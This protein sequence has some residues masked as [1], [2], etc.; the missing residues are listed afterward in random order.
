M[1]FLA[2]ISY[3]FVWKLYSLIIKVILVIFYNFKIGKNF[4][5]KGTPILKLKGNNNIE[6]GNNV[7]ILGDIDLRTREN[8]KLIILD[9]V[10]IEENCRFVVAKEG[11]TKIGNNTVIGAY[12]IWNGGG[13]ITI[14]K[15]CIFSSRSSINANEHVFEK[16]NDSPE[17]TKFNYGNVIIEDQ[18][19][20]G[21]NT[22]I[23]LNTVIGQGAIIGAHSFVNSN[24]ESCSIN[25][26]VP[27][28]KIKTR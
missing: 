18:C 17:T 10:K 12:A 14:G 7:R 23:S 11:T 6:I 13:N 20:I 9:N 5:I 22:S 3:D 27:A 16:K 15:N 24:L 4:F 2:L 21:I 19:F 28:K 26:G 1:K 25:V 8:G